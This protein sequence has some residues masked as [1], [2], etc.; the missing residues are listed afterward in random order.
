MRYQML[1]DWNKL[2]KVLLF[3][4][5][6]LVGLVAVVFKSDML[7]TFCSILC[8]ITAL[9][10]AKGKNLGQVL[11][12]IITVV[13]SI[14]SFRNGFYGEII[15]YVFM[16]LPMYIIGIVSWMRH[17][18]KKTNSVEVNTVGKKEWLLVS[19]VSIGIFIGVYFL[20]KSFGT[21]ELVVSAVSV[22]ASLF[23]IY[24]QIRRS[25][26]SFYF[27]IIN[28]LVLIVLWGIPVIAGNL[29]ILP[30]VFNPTINLINDSYGVYNW[31][32]LEKRQTKGKSN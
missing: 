21:N 14:V 18:N 4:S 20:L 17:Q 30:M 28:D 29:L 26:F 2:E 8:T 16:M 11:G 22:I 1:K 19:L 10:V 7:S 3:G 15:I 6:V 32:K 13:Y 23:A 9:L 31:K 25:R 5:I 12:V 24:L 27:Y